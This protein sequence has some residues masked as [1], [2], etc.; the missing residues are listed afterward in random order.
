MIKDNAKTIVCFGDSNTWGN[1]PHSDFRYPRS[2][3]WPGALQ[4]LLGDAYEVISEGLCGR[5]LVAS[6]P[7]KPHR[8]GIT[9]IQAIVESADPVDLLI[10]M[11]GTNDVKNNYNLEP[12]D[13]SAHLEQYVRLIEDEKFDLTKKPKILIICPPPVITPKTNDLDPRMTKGPELFRVL[14]KSYKEV[15]NTYGCGFIHAGDH[16][17][18]SDVD[19]YHLSKDAH[20]KLAGVVQEWI[21]QNL[22]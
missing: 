2:V 21:I 6:D 17:T 11:L 8:T 19:G 22:K 4:G 10:I 1:V 7:K 15:A 5:T 9:H 14:P 16:I 3:R 13:I 18:S 12:K 20:L